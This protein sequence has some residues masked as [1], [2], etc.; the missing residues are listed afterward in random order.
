MHPVVLLH[1]MGWDSR[2]WDDWFHQFAKKYHTIRYDLRGFG[3]SGP[4]PLVSYSHP[5]DL[6]A[7]LSHL[8]LDSVHVMGHS[9][10]GYAAVDFALS[11]PDMTDAL[12]LADPAP[13]RREK[14]SE[15]PERRGSSFRHLS[16]P[17][18]FQN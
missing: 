4:P 9:L 3:Q 16:G 6:A 8:G 15:L 17:W 12:V 7:L 2:A 10:D 1:G 18:S 11:Y 13:S 5:D 14:V